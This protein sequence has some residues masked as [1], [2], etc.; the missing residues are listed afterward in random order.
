MQRSLISTSLV[1]TM[2]LIAGWVA[3]PA[4]F[5]FQP[6]SQVWVEGTSSLHDWTCQVNEFG[7]LLEAASAAMENLNQVRVTV[8]VEQLKCKNGTMNKKTYKALASDDHPAITYEL[9]S[10]T[11]NAS[12]ADG[13]FQLETTGALTI[14]GTTRDVEMTVNGEPLDDGMVRLIGSLPLLMTDFGVDPPSAMLGTL[15]TGNEVTVHFD[16]VVAR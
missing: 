2:L 9:K 16:V 14:A 11:L 7:G 12:E 13:I 8:P 1:L 10:A 15:K 6:E 4:R 3:T 5:T